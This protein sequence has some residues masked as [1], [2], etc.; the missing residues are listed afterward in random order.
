MQDQ[1][2]EDLLKNV[3]NIAQG[4]EGLQVFINAFKST[5]P[6][7]QQKQVD[8]ELKRSNF[9]KHIAKAKREFEKA[10]KDIENANN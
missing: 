4:V 3:N 7:D 9:E 6:E 1:I 5:L 2:K 8:A 10:K